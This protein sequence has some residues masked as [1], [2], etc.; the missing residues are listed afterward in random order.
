[1]AVA[2]IANKLLMFAFYVIAAHRLGVTDYGVLSFALAFVTML[3]VFTDLG[4]GAVTAREIARD[5]TVA[6]RY[7]SNTVAIKLVASVVVVAMT[8]L[9]VN[10]LR[11][12]PKTV[13]V[14][15]ICSGFVLESA[16][17]SYFVYVFQGFEKMQFTA[18]TRLIQSGVLIVG[19]V[20]IPNGPKALEH[21]AVL[22][23]AAGLASVLFA[24]AVTALAFVRFK[25]SFALSEWRQMLRS[26]APIGLTIGLVTFYYWNGSALLSKM[27]GDAAVGAYSAAFRLTFGAAFLGLAFSGALYPLLSRLFVANTQRLSQ[28]TEFGLRYVTILV[29]PIAVVGSTLAREVIVLV[30]GV[31]Y[32]ESVTVFRIVV[33][34]C[35]FATINSLLS[36]YFMA[37]DKP[38]VVTIQSSISLGVNVLGNVF[39][40]PVLGAVGAAIS[41]V[42]AETAGVIY[43]SIRQLRTIGSICFRR[44]ALAVLQVV[45]AL[46]PAVIIAYT[47]AR[48]NLAAA[49]T[50]TMIIY[51]TVLVV[52][53]GINR[54]DF[55]LVRT[56]V[57]RSDV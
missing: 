40:I 39:L 2:D 11:Y 47:V 55:E 56:M 13:R 49:F 37:I 31:T 24:W 16:F 41:I 10:L 3:A 21:Y 5:H 36:N 12:P 22:Y 46:V 18:L 57:R 48:W 9:L 30:Y 52:T 38:A 1:L 8:V 28:V 50:L 33:W 19:V 14:V 53:R 42:C 32:H 15:Y 54:R 25:L 27:H 20:V 43:L 4:L 26:A 17:T 45:A 7:I 35:A 29:L 44:Y 34:W 51:L 6:R 23:V